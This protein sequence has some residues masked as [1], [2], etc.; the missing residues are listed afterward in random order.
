MVIL[1]AFPT[2]SVFPINEKG[3]PNLRIV[4]VFANRNLTIIGANRP[5]KMTEKL[6]MFCKVCR[7]LVYQ[8]QF[9]DRKQIS[10]KVD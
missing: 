10:H 8:S 1:L 4:V 3:S 9:Y 7:V 2:N 5:V 6:L